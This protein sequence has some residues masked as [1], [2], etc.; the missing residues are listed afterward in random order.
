MM[1]CKH[2]GY[3]LD[4]G[5]ISCPNCSTEVGTGDNFCSMCGTPRMSGDNFCSVCGANFSQSMPHND[6]NINSVSPVQQSA[7]S[8]NSGVNKSVTGSGQGFD[9]KAYF[10]EW[11]TNLK[12]VL[13]ISDK[14]E[15]VLRYASYAAS[16]LIFILMMFPVVSVHVEAIFY[17]YNNA[18]NLFAVST[19][20]AMMYIFA[21][22][23]SLATFLPH[24]KRFEQNNKKLVPFM[25]LI[26]PF[27]EL[28]GM[29]SM[30]IGVGVTNAA[31]TAYLGN[32]ASVRLGFVGWL[33]LI[34]TLGAVGAAVYH[35]IKYD[36]EYMKENNPF[37][38]TVSKPKDT[39]TNA[40]NNTYQDT[41][42]RGDDVKK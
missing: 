22:L 33:I 6:Y 11:L 17:E 23:C 16:A 40:M 29:L 24:V 27:L 34:I 20:G 28:V 30:L 25:Y 39:I 9:F 18:S 21:L 19:F 12:A 32:L 3:K 36:L 14:L 5:M 7:V 4:D 35:V 31:V 8:T 15:M 38:S 26:V 41:V 13:N 37:V 42:Y 2:C 1:Y 10:G